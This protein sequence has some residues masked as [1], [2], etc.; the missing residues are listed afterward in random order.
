MRFRVAINQDK[1]QVLNFCKNTFTWG[2]YIERVWDIWINEPNSR[3]LVAEP[4]NEIQK[5]IAIIHG[6]LLQ[7]KTMWIEGIRVDPKYRRQKIALQLIN[8]ILEYGRKNG[9]VFSAAIVSIKNQ[10]SKGLMEKSGFEIVSKWSYISTYQ[11]RFSTNSKDVANNCKV[12]ESND[13]KE[14]MNYLKNSEIFKISGK[15]FVNSW[16]WYNLT[17]NNLLIMINNKQIIIAYYKDNYNISYN[18]QQKEVIGISI[19]D[20]EIQYAEQ[21]IIK[22]EYIDADSEELLHSLIN[23]NIEITINNNKKYNNK[24]E[25]NIEN[26]DLGFQ[27]FTPFREYNYK[28][29]PKSSIAFFDQFLLYCKKI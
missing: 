24:N 2:D 16:R 8:Q 9:A 6:I 14:I 15:K 27:I 12:A 20:K 7:E 10:P 22:I 3:L 23:K 21:N 18:K 25:D 5:P 29:F 1:D 28:I 13:F 11:T 17:E 19:I 26:K 4:E